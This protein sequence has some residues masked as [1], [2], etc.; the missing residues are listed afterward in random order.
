MDFASAI[1]GRQEVT[2]VYDGLVRVVQPAT[3]GD[4]TTGKRTLRACQVAGESRRNNVPCWELYTESKMGNPQVTGAV[5]T[6][7]AV[8]G[9]A[10]SDKGF[11]LIVAEH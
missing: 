3:Y 1:A 2:F 5:F 7:F 8:T 4:T 6:S 10:K 9:Y 11:A